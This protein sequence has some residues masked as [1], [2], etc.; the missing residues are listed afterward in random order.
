MYELDISNHLDKVFSKLAKKD[1]ETLK[2]IYKKIEQILAN[3]EHFKPLR[4]PLQHL[5]GVH[6]A[7]SF[8]L[9]YEIDENRKVVKLIDYDHHDKIFKHGWRGRLG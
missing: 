7:K 1:K 3:P 8:V 2:F 9:T 6:I 4:K 5:R